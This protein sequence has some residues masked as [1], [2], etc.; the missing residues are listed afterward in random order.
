MTATQI[1]Q[2]E[3]YAPENWLQMIRDFEL[4]DVAGELYDIPLSQFENGEREIGKLGGDVICQVID[5]AGDEFVLFPPQDIEGRSVYVVGEVDRDEK[6][7]VGGD[8]KITPTDDGGVMVNHDGDNRY[9]TGDELR[10]VATADDL[11]TVEIQ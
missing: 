9:V 6:L 10:N 1:S 2:V 5:A 3:T 8:I 11:D 7:I 4:E